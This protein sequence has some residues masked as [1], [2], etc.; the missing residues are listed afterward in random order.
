M[1]EARCLEDFINVFVDDK[2]VRNQNEK[3]FI[4]CHVISYAMQYMNNKSCKVVGDMLRGRAMAQVVNCRPR[5][6][7]GSV[8]V[9]F[10]VDKVAL[11]QVFP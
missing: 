10:V 3:N 11:G 2:Y 7:S 9:G 6:S 4:L 5:F 1:A 8:P